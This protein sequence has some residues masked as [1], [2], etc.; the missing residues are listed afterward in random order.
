MV[1][2]HSNLEANFPL[3]IDQRSNFQKVIDRVSALFREICFCLILAYKMFLGPQNY[4]YL[5]KHYAWKQDS[6]GLFVFVHG[7]LAHPSCWDTHVDLVG[8]RY[9]VF[10][11][12]VPRRGVCS[13]E[14]AADPIYEHVKRYALAHPDRK[15][16]VIGHSNGS[17]IAAYIEAKLREDAPSVPVRVSTIAGVILG[18]SRQSVAKCMG[19]DRCFCPTLSDE[20][21]YRSD[22]ANEIFNTL[23]ASLNPDVAQRSYEFFGT[24]DD[25]LVDIESSLPQIHKGETHH[26]LYGVGH[27][28]IVEKVAAL[29]VEK[30]KEWFS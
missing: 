26:A 28:E 4:H 16:C 11:P 14:E 10:T 25:L 27:C 3:F 29:Q 24:F 17:R 30:A 6:P 2:V 7:L 8:S 5:D 19:I 23:K 15:I 22:K 21:A 18:S 13:L 1:A 20:I 12:F 9:D